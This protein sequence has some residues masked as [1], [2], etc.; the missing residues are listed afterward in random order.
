MRT[1]HFDI[2]DQHD[3]ETFGHL[4]GAFAVS[5]KRPTTLEEMDT[6]L[7]V[8]RKLHRLSTDPAPGS[9]ERRLAQS[10]DVLLEEAEYKYLKE[11]VYPPMASWTHEGLF[12]FAQ[13][14]AKLEGAA[15]DALPVTRNGAAAPVGVTAE[16]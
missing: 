4:S 6:A 14:R 8:L 1:L 7:A 15:K 2:E 16:A 5:G 3:T 9:K 10:G 12:A 11:A 13:V